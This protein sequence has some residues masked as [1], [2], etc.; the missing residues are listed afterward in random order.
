MVPYVFALE[1]RERCAVG[2]A[3]FVPKGRKRRLL[4]G[5]IEPFQ[6][7]VA[8]DR[9]RPGGA[10]AAMSFMVPGSSI[11]DPVPFPLFVAIQDEEVLA[12]PVE[13]PPVGQPAP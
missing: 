13:P 8:T 7:G 1:R 9:S 11:V 6:R 4:R 12:A 5:G 3:A 2:V 10:L